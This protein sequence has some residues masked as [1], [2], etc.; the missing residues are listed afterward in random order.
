M[1]K[2]PL[3]MAAGREP[4]DTAAGREGLRERAA[5]DR[6]AGLIEGAEGQL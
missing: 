6:V 4:A 1:L 2:D 5:I 3:H